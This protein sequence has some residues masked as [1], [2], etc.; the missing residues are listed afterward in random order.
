VGAPR[1]QGL[2]S[3]AG[4]GRRR[5]SFHRRDG[6]R[7]PDIVGHRWFLGCVG[8][9]QPDPTGESPV[10]TEKPPARYGAIWGARAT[11]FTLPSYTGDTTTRSCLMA[12]ESNLQQ[13]RANMMFLKRFAV[14]IPRRSAEP[15]VP[16]IRRTY[17]IACPS[18]LPLAA[19]VRPSRYHILAC[20]FWAAIPG[21]RPLAMSATYQR[22]FRQPFDR[23]PRMTSAANTIPKESTQR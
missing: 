6:G 11:G 20:L 16:E 19:R 22:L 18:A 9:S 13:A 1:A 7:L 5:G 23:R 8:V 21:V 15:L 12:E 4:K 3:L 14:S 17:I 2:H 10:T